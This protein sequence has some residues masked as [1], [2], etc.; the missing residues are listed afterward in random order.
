MQLYLLRLSMRGNYGPATKMIGQDKRQLIW[1]ILQGEYF[2]DTMCSICER[3]NLNWIHQMLQKL[4]ESIVTVKHSTFWLFRGGL[5][6]N[7]SISSEGWSFI[8]PEA[9]EDE[10]NR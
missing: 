7:T 1:D 8:H 6:S 9:M 2:S 10:L 4:S 3:Q 5:Q